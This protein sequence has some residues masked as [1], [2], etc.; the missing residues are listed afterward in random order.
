MTGVGFAKHNVWSR[1]ARRRRKSQD[2]PSKE[3]VED[4]DDW[5]EAALGFRIQAKQSK[6]AEHAEVIIRWLKGNDTV[7]FESFCGMLKRQLEDR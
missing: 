7:L 3:T 2:L 5:D 1:A 4:D 6:A